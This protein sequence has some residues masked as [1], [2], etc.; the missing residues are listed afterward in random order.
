M[1]NFSIYDDIRFLYTNYKDREVHMKLQTI[2]ITTCGIILILLTL[3]CH[4]KANV[5]SN[6]LLNP[7]EKY[8]CKICHYE[9][10]CY[11]G[12]A[13][14]CNYQY[15]YGDNDFIANQCCPGSIKEIK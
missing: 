1:H 11:R 13:D 10:H 15:F 7:E 4:D 9:T 12:Y 5:I 3:G 8:I 14:D 2:L 6:P